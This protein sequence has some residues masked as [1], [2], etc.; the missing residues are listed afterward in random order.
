[1]KCKTVSALLTAFSLFSL[2]GVQPSMANEFFEDCNAGYPDQ[3]TSLY[4]LPYLP[5]LEFIVGQGNCT[6]GSHEINT[7]QEYAYDFD[8][9]IGTNIVASRGGVVMV[10]VDH[11]L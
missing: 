8:M 3:N 10:V 7:D 6:D 4:V 11:F 5:T 9:P 2:G 1:M